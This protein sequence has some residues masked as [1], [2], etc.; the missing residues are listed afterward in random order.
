MLNKKLFTTFT[1]FL[2]FMILTSVLK[3]Q[4]RIIEKKI[5]ISMRNISV[6]KNN[7]YESQLEYSYLS[8]PSYISNKILKYSDKEYSTIELSRIYLSLEQFLK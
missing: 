6:I 5:E 1:I 3:T 8:S 2:F 7:L 4:T